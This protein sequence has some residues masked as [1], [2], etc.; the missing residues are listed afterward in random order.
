MQAI[1]HG[2]KPS[3]EEGPSQAQAEELVEGQ[4]HQD[5]KKLP[6][7]KRKKASKIK[8]EKVKKPGSSFDID[9]ARRE[10][11]ITPP[12]GP[13][14][15]QPKSAA[16]VRGTLIRSEQNQ[17]LDLLKAFER[18]DDY[19]LVDPREFYGALQAVN[20]RV[21]SWV[22]DASKGLKIGDSRDFNL[23][24][25]GVILKIRKIAGDLYS[26][27]ILDKIGDIEHLYDRISLPVLATQIM[28][29][30]EVYDGGETSNLRSIH[31]ELSSINQDLKE[32]K[33]KPKALK[34]RLHNL[35]ANLTRIDQMSADSRAKHVEAH[36]KLVDR[37]EGEL[38]NIHVKLK[39]L[40][41]AFT[42][43]E[44][45]SQPDVMAVR[46]LGRPGPCTDCGS[47][48]CQCYLHLTKPC[49]EI[50]PSGKVTIM[51]KSDWNSLDKVNFLKSM[52]YVMEKKNEPVS[53]NPVH[54]AAHVKSSPYRDTHKMV[55]HTLLPT[56]GGSADIPFSGMK[57]KDYKYGAN[58]AWELSQQKKGNKTHTTPDPENENR[59]YISSWRKKSKE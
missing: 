20:K 3:K 2:W 11:K 58:K 16:G 43:P 45:D 54:L 7:K 8:K 23:P 42:P 12:K 53:Y 35:I 24:I 57:G 22:Q 33:Q 5:Y 56:S 18:R 59:V 17:I 38:N 1:S 10:Q 31:S 55:S 4:S 34:E 44:V 50:E 14:V 36:N 48:K 37:T 40:R 21:L 19:T 15:Y 46:R 49:I 41:D 51:F 27:W 25:D 6:E 30:Y 13:K 9:A 29:V 26:G 28:S 47:P 32:K 39:N 52:K